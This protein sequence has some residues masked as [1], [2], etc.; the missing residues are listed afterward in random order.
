MSDS[1]SASA[2]CDT[3]AGL[4]DAFSRY[5]DLQRGLSAHTVRAYLGDLADLLTF[6]GVGE[7][8]AEPVGPALASLELA[9]L[10][11]WLATMS[12]DGAARATLARRAAACRA[13]ST[14]AFRNGLL[15]AD[16]AARLRSPRAD[17]RLPTVLT[18]AQATALLDAAADAV[19]ATAA[20]PDDGHGDPARA[21]ALALR[22]RAAL[23]TLYATGVRVSELCALDLTDVDASR[24]TM[25]VLGKGN[26]ERTVPYGGPAA[27]AL[28][29]WL[30]ARASLAAPEA[31]SA[32]F[33]GARGRRIDPR[34]VREIVHRAAARAGVPDLGPHGLRHSAATHVLSGGADLRSVQE[35]LGHSSLATTQR[36]THVSA[37]RLRAVYAQAFPRA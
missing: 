26:R 19:A 24:R 22:D 1:A 16:V 7:Q 17:A 5:L 32:L 30:G 28:E 2:A 18:P 21:R 34:A 10:R 33:L 13:F 8:E 23:E 9:D 11:A 4:L 37:E 31:G 25:R 12:A 14:W 20:E 27:R 36:Y 35:L 29:D 3:R 6:L 15:E